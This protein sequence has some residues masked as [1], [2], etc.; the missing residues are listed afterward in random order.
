MLHGQ[1]TV[2][3]GQPHWWQGGVIYQVYI[4]SFRDTNGDGVGDLAG[5][6]EKLPYL[7]WL[8][9]DAIWIT[10]FYPS[11]M[12]D[13]GYDVADYTNVDPLF[14]DLET[15][16][17]LIEQAHR[18]GIKVIVDYVPNHTSSEHSWFRES[19]SSRT[20]PKR[21]WYI[22]RD[23]KDS[24]GA[25]GAPPNNWLSVFGGP[26]WEWDA[27]TEQYYLHSFHK[28]QPDLNWRNPAV[29]AAM[30]DAVRFWLERGVDGFRID[31]AILI[32]KDPE[33][34]DNPPDPDPD[35]V[36]VRTMGQWAT[37]LHLY[38]LAH[39]DVHGVYREFRQ[40][41]ESYSDGQPRMSVGELHDRDPK[42][43]ASYYGAQLDELHMPFNFHLIGVEWNTAL[44]RAIVDG[45]DAAVPAGAWPNW[46][47]GNH[48][49]SR[50]ASHVG[51]AQA[52][53]AMLLLL[54]LRGTPTL[55]YG[56][57]LGMTNGAIPPESVRD[58]WELQV[59]GL[60]RDPQRT[61]MQWDA[62]PNA[63]FCPPGVVPWLPIASN[64]TQVN[65]AAQASEPHSMLA[66]TRGL[67]ALRRAS[68]ALSIG[69]Y[70]SLDGMPDGCFVYLRHV[71][72][73][74][75][76]VALNFTDSAQVLD[77]PEAMRGTIRLSTYADRAGEAVG[78]QLRLR[79]D[80]GCV[81]E[82]SV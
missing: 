14:G 9:I 50:I 29:K 8:G 55:Y 39:P 62:S 16:D 38:D 82:L 25:P 18:Q 3:T 27:T 75:M 12:R 2:V 57:E 45:I 15:F 30:F 6:I 74:H 61:P 17:R 26:A 32:M 23:P 76:L 70:R 65:V 56:D 43:W 7:E 71:T 5:V 53:V 72:N 10:P 49:Q 31:V 37:Q 77:L 60:G 13:F 73:Q 54:T 24:R 64:Y 69:E 28:D 1:P 41:L 81:L 67:L 51:A 20:N 36:W 68:P 78:G 48:D 52:R 79:G 35:P 33:L 58:P 80:E 44:V 42:I 66:L 46:V 63:G 11:P 22:W 40:L 34:R 4:R 47:L 21:D 19:R 59:P